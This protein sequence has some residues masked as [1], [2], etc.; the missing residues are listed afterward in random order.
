MGKFTRNLSTLLRT[1]RPTPGEEPN[2]PGSMLDRVRPFYHALDVTE[3]MLLGTEF[4]VVQVSNGGGSDFVDGLT[5]PPGFIHWVPYCSISHATATGQ[6]MSIRMREPAPGT[7]EVALSHTLFALS[8]NRLQIINNPVVVPPGHT[9]VG[10]SDNGTFH[11][12][13]IEYFYMV[14]EVSERVWTGI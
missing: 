13:T 10:R 4:R 1:F 7:I 14:L 6:H 11:N 2:A 12:I 3:R 8:Q 9:L 5:A